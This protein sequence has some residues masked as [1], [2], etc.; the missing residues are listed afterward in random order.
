MKKLLFAIIITFCLF[1]QTADAGWGGGWMGSGNSKLALQPRN[2]DTDI[3]IGGTNTVPTSGAGTSG[4]NVMVDYY[5]NAG[6]GFLNISAASSIYSNTPIISVRM[7]FAAQ[8]TAGVG[9]QFRVARVRLGST[10][11]NDSNVS[12]YSVASTAT[13]TAGAKTL[14]LSTPLDTIPGDVLAIWPYNYTVGAN[15]FILETASE[16]KS[17][18]GGIAG[19]VYYRN[20]FYGALPIKSF[21]QAPNIV[22]IG[23]SRVVANNSTL[24][25]GSIWGFKEASAPLVKLGYK[26][27][28]PM[29]Y[30]V[31]TP[32]SWVYQN[33]GV[34]GENCTEVAARFATDVVA[35]K[36]SYAL[37]SCG[38]ND[39]LD[40]HEAETTVGKIEDMVNACL[41][42]TPAI[43]PIV[44]SVD[45]ITSGA[46]TYYLGAQS[47][48]FNKLAYTLN[49]LVKTAVEAIPGAIFMDTQS[50]LSTFTAGAEPYYT[51]ADTHAA[52]EID[53]VHYN[54]AALKLVGEEYYRQ[55]RAKLTRGSTTMWASRW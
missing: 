19:G 47:I 9:A 55:L 49:G 53:G 20:T 13:L 23:D 50:V 26:T 38:A 45:P 42:A 28:I 5:K 12:A 7:Y 11:L 37:I 15:C 40:E 43:I 8:L 48:H 2:T 18:V 54:T 31:A 1:L 29:I 46:N 51:M 34:S 39:I 21:W 44:T 52:S 14:T 27:T 24:Y 22:H 10:S 32:F 16:N 25:D 36:P 3:E 33:M 30:H 4:S 6:L 17:D 35:K 41:E